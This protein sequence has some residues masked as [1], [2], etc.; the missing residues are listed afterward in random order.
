MAEGSAMDGARMKAL[1]EAKGLSQADFARWLNE[2]V[3]RSYDRQ[4]VSKWEV[5]AERIPQIVVGSLEIAEIERTRPADDAPRRGLIVAAAN[6]K[7]GVAKTATS[8]NLA[9]LLAITGNRVLLVD[10][11]PQGNA[12]AHVGVGHAQIVELNN[13]ERTL[14]HVLVGRTPIAEVVTETYVPDLHLLP[15]SITL[16]NADGELTTREPTGAPMV[17]REKLAAVRSTYDVIV[18]DCAPNL[19]LTTINALTAAD[20]LVVPCQAEPHSIL[21]L[22]HLNETVA[23]VRS[24]TNPGLRMLGVVPTMFNGRLSQDQASLDEL[25]QMW[26]GTTT[27]YEPVPRATIYAQAAAANRITLEADFSAPGRDTYLAL[28][29]D[30][31][32]IAGLE[33]RHGQAA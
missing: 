28:A 9:Y 7:G 32:K 16:S 17:L 3:G 5:G 14:Y 11:D 24:R 10:A 29:R 13:A 6:Q 18:I 19:G 33:D 2:R 27:V 15:S 1:R 22:H 30:I 20:Q 26:S 21:G 31:M 23:K 8:V 4:R 12:T 25:T